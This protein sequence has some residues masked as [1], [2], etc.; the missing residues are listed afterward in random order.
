M[1]ASGGGAGPSRPAPRN[2]AQEFQALHQ[3]IPT[4]TLTPTEDFPADKQRQSTYISTNDPWAGN[5]SKDARF[6]LKNQ[7]N[8]H[9]LRREQNE[10]YPRTN[11]FV[12]TVQEY[13]SDN[14]YNDVYDVV[15]LNLMVQREANEQ[16]PKNRRKDD[17]NTLEGSWEQMWRHLGRFV[18]YDEPWPE[19]PSDTMYFR[20]PSEVQ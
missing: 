20:N 16:L 5:F 14:Q 11:R 17:R 8:D 13:I 18:S 4:T 19:T 15:R 9:R 10:R 2:A 7:R 12:P 3:E 1:S 6:I